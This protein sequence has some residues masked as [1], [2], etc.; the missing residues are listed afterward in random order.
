MKTVP[1]RE[2]L[3]AVLCHDLTQIIPGQFKGPA[4]RKGHILREEDIPRL[5]EMGKEHVFVWETHDGL[6]HENGLLCAWPGPLPVRAS[7]FRAPRKAKWI[8]WRTGTAC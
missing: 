8:S 2:A 4:F 6:L 3:G 5:L 1:V 7:P